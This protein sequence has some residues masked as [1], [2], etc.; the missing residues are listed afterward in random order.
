[1]TLLLKSVVPVWL[2]AVVGAILVG[3]LVAPR[4]YLV[5]L[6]VVLGVATL[7]T[8]CIQLGIRRKEGFVNRATASTAGVFVIL[9][10]ATI[11]LAPI[12]LAAA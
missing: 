2:L 3:L 1:V 10:V 5:Y 12:A 11:V 8:F 4:D 6:P 7:L 9:A